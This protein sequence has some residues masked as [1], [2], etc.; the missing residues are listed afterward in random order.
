MSILA[1]ALAKDGKCRALALSGG[2]NKGAWEAGVLWGLVHYREA[3]D[4]T[5]DVSSG[6]SAGALNTAFAAVWETGS[7]TDM[8]EALSEVWSSI[9][10]NSEIYVSWGVPSAKALF[11]KP[12]LVNTDPGLQFL[13]DAIEPYES[14]KRRFT[15]GA[16]DV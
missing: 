16:V 12:S 13:K 5:W 2:G 4:F 1:T 3:D 8:T 9:S 15:N 6:I 14:V 10:E 7:E 11:T